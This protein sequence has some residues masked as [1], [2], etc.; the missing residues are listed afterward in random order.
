MKSSR[1]L[2]LATLM[3]FALSLTAWAK[4]K[5]SAY[6]TL[7]QPVKLAG[8]QLAPGYYHV[9]WTGNSPNV[10]VT[11]L[12]DGK[13]MVTAPAKLEMQEDPYQSTAVDMKTQA[14]GT[15]LLAGIMLKHVTLR[16]QPASG[17]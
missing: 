14:K 3:L 11:F 12:K 15:P 16:F 5:D 2:T 6:V 9:L 10:T 4:T 17:K 13:K 8:T 1:L 7:W